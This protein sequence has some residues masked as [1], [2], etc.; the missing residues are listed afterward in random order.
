MNSAVIAHWIVFSRQN[1]KQLKHY[2]S[3]TLL[4]SPRRNAGEHQSDKLTALSRNNI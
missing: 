2:R 3:L 4:T 1:R